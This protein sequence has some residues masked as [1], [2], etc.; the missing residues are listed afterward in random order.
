MAVL[1]QLFGEPPLP[2][3]L[4]LDD[5]T[6]IGRH[7]DCEVIVPSPAVSRFH[8]RITCENDRF[9]VEDLNS[10]NGTLLNG[11]KIQERTL[12][13]D[14]D[15]V[16][17]STLPYAFVTQNWLS[18]AAGSWG[19]KAKV[20]SVSSTGSDNEDSIR[21]LIVAPGDHI[22]NDDLGT[23]IVREGQVVNRM[24]ITDDSAWPVLTDATQKLNHVLRMVYGLRRTIVRDEVISCVLQNLFDVFQSAERIA[25]VLRNEHGKGIEVAA[26]VSRL[27]DEE[28]QICL[29]V[30]RSCMQ[31]TEAML[32]VDHWKGETSG[33]AELENPT[34]RSIMCVPLIGVIGHSIGAIQ[35]DNKNA[36]RPLEKENL[37]QLVVIS[38]VISFAMEQAV[39]AEAEVARAVLDTNIASAERLRSQLAPTAPPEVRGYRLAHE[40]IP[41]PDMAADLIDYVTLPDGRIAC[42]LLDVSARG[43]ESGDLMALLARQ[44]IGAVTETGS[45]AEAIRQTEETLSQRLEHVPTVISVAVLILDPKRST[46]TFS[47]AGHCPLAFI[48]KN[49]VKELDSSDAIGPPLGD[50]RDS[51]VESEIELNDNDVILLCS[52]GITKLMSP[53]GNFLSRPQMVAMIKDAASAHR[54]VFESSLRRRL[55]AHRSDAPLVDDVAFVIIHRSKSATT[56]VNQ[57]ISTAE[58]ETQDA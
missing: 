35:V 43:P 40:L 27:P 6:T 17:F 39:A 16:E 10:R 56:I 46:V 51:C 12:L 18:E 42:L 3:F 48:H 20:I 33:N 50:G 22:S 14:G 2:S 57:D 53:A 24:S 32:Y 44:L 1:Q 15:Q 13:N 11:Q 37:E 49:Q 34:M 54:T 31:N 8:A 25:V 45:A 36:R 30:V 5:V 7:D 55:T 41:A 28:V 47:V 38:Q 29:P 4:I 9:F 23:D 19:V 21:R 26:A 58:S 52:D